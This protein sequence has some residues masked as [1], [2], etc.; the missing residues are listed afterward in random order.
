MLYC[1]AE[2]FLRQLSRKNANQQPK[3]QAQSQSP[4]VQQQS[5]HSNARSISTK[6]RLFGAAVEPTTPKK[7]LTNTYKSTIFDSSAPSSPAR[8]PKKSIPVL[9]RNPITG[10]VKYSPK[11]T[12]N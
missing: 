3:A 6:E 5:E 11:I 2:H 1:L 10:E 9:D 7:K 8:T 12:A 4:P